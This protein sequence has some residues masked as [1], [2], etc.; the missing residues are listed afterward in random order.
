MVD[1]CAKRLIEGNERYLW[2]EE[3]APE[4]KL[5]AICHIA[6]NEFG[7]GDMQIQSEKEFSDDFCTSIESKL[8]NAGECGICLFTMQWDK[9]TVVTKCGHAFHKKCIDEAI[10]GDRQKICPNCRKDVR[11]EDLVAVNDPRAKLQFVEVEP[12]AEKTKQWRD[13]ERAQEENM[14]FFARA[15]GKLEMPFVIK[16]VAHLQTFYEEEDIEGITLDHF[17]N[18]YIADNYTIRMIHAGEKEEQMFYYSDDSDSEPKLT[19]AHGIVWVP[20]K[21]NGNLFVTDT[22][23]HV[24]FKISIDGK[25]I[26]TFAGTAKGNN[27]GK[28][29]EAQFNEP[30]GIA[31]DRHGNLFV[32]DGTYDHQS[33]RKISPEGVVTTFANAELLRQMLKEKKHQ[34]ANSVAVDMKGNVF[35]SMQ[36]AVIAFS[37][38]GKSQ[39][40]GWTNHNITK[41][42]VTKNGNFFVTDAAKNRVLKIST[43]GKM[44]IFQKDVGL[45][46]HAI[47]ADN[48]G[49]VF[50]LSRRPG[51][52]RW[53]PAGKKGDEYYEEKGYFYDDVMVNK[54]S[55]YPQ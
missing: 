9:R 37:P 2:L 13:R 41:M 21:G 15:K 48:K 12:G 53:R 8:P 27:D 3:V 45:R 52:A 29:T 30:R 26:T 22:W 10:A 14:R 24:I 47:T 35:L 32:V 50:F 38:K 23:R 43:K 51:A 46:P 54:L 16:E 28:G 11:P 31:A 18:I 40:L 49:N 20:G 44:V 19:T 4:K 6:R 55:L 39:H 5:A 36:N 25:E 1:R 17:G 42:T 33:I 34:R 7:I